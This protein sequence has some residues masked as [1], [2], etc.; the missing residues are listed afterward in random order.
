MATDTL[1]DP[2]LGHLYA[3]A[4]VAIARADDQIGV[5]EGLRLQ[6][7]V[8][9]RIG[10]PIALDDLLLA[11]SLEPHRLAETVR[12]TQPFRN[13]GVHPGELAMM[14]I[15]DGIAVALAKGYVAE[16]EAE[17]IMRFAR[18]LGC[19]REQV[20]QLFSRVAPWLA[21]VV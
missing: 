5:E 13:S 9:Q 20:N 10:G 17:A 11:D 14:I 6:Q 21:A 12:G 2:D 1:R 19:S 15:H 18:A 8:E 3:R 16:A 4:L 7:V